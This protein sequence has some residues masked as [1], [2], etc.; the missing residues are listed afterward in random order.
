MESSLVYSTLQWVESLSVYSI[1][2]T[3]TVPFT[4]EYVHTCLRPAPS[5]SILCPPA[6][7][8]PRTTLR[9]DHLLT[10]STT[11]VFSLIRSSLSLCIS[12]ALSLSLV[13][14]LSSQYSLL[15][16]CDTYIITYVGTKV[17]S[18]CIQYIHTKSLARRASQPL[19]CCTGGPPSCPR[20]PLCLSTCRIASSAVHLSGRPPQAWFALEPGGHHRVLIKTP[21]S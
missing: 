17:T 6:R 2:C 7:Q 3:G 4:V 10:L 9:P 15:R 8:S 11:L 1:Y 19:C 14:V 5:A 12:L 20:P 16:P 13:R 18:T 21:S